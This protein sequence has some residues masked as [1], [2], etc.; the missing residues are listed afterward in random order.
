MLQQ[1]TF[2]R[3][4][5]LRCADKAN[6]RHSNYDDRYKTRSRSREENHNHNHNR[7]NKEQV[8]SQ[9]RYKF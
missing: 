3:R 6:I 9:Q 2:N 4:N 5:R 1:D 7:N 8:S